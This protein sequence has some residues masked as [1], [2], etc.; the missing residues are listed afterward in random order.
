[1]INSLLTKFYNNFAIIYVQYSSK[2]S[3]IKH[4]NIICAS[5]G[6]LNSL[7]LKS[8]QNCPYL[9]FLCNQ[10]GSLLN[11]FYLFLIFLRNQIMEISFFERTNLHSDEDLVLYL[12]HS[13]NDKRSEVVCVF[14]FLCFPLK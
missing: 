7:K 4:Y 13:E 14:G 5:H 9:N 12:E 1:M 3:Y 11:H 2:S 6:Q 10:I 8:K